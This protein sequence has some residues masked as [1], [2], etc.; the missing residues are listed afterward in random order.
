MAEKRS[1]NPLKSPLSDELFNHKLI[2]GLGVMETITD[3]D[4]IVSRNIDGKRGNHRELLMLV[5]EKTGVADIADV[6][7]CRRDKRMMSLGQ[8][9]ALATIDTVLRQAC[10][11]DPTNRAGPRKY[12]DFILDRGFE[13]VTILYCG[14]YLLWLDKKTIDEADFI[15]IEPGVWGRFK[16]IEVDKDDAIAFFKFELDWQKEWWDL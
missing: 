3:L 5:E 14:L 12:E 6:R 8:R 13:M 7:E 16:P 15:A 11:V 4:F 1:P 9:Y 10:G 2:S